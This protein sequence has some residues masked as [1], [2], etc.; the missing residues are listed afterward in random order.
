[1]SSLRVAFLVGLALAVFL[2]INDDLIV[3]TALGAAWLRA[4][5]LIQPMA[6]AVALIFLLQVIVPVLNSR[7]RP[8]I[9]VVVQ[10]ISIGLFLVLV[11]LVASDA[12]VQVLWALAAAYA[13]RVI[14]LLYSVTFFVQL[15]PLRLLHAALPGIWTAMLLVAADRAM[16]AMLPLEFSGIVRLAAIVGISVTV[17]GL[18]CLGLV[19]RVSGSFGR[20]LIFGRSS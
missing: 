6:L 3:E 17:F 16:D 15:K 1:L 2:S 12:P 10:L 11:A 19:G 14:C 13:C 7:G 20:R 9:E 8:E 5:P 18:V 4:V